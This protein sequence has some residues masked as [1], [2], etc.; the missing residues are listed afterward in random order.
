MHVIATAGHVDHGK[1]TLV[2]RLTSMEPDR[3]SEERR[4]GLTIDLGFAWTTLDDGQR[5]AFVDVPGHERFV[6]NML[7]GIGEVPAVMFVVAADEG[8]MPQSEEHLAALDAL[9]VR[10]GLLAVTRSDLTDPRPATELVLERIGRTSLGRLPA[11]AVSGR[12]GEGVTELRAR[13]AELVRGLPAPDADADVRLW[14]D[15]S[16]S[17]RGAGT[18]V[19][20]TL[21]GGTITTEDELEV[22]S[23]GQAVRVRGIQTLGERT[24]GVSGLAR[25][26][27]N[28]RGVDTDV[29]TRG[30]ALVTPQA[31]RGTGWVDVALREHDGDLPGELV[32]HVGSAAVTVRP[33]RL[34][35]GLARLHLAR[36]LPLRYGDVALLRD[37]GQHIV[38]DGLRVL[39]VDP[40]GLTRRGAARARAAQLAELTDRSKASEQQ[41]RRR[42]FV[43]AGDL[44]WM[45]L[46][47]AGVELRGWHADPQRWRNAQ[48]EL[49]A[50]VRA[51]QSSHPLQPG[52]PV[53]VVRQRLG[54]PHGLANEAAR[55]TG[56]SIVDGQVRFPDAAA[57]LPQRVESALAKLERDLA[58]NPFVAPEAARLAELKLDPKALAAAVR[59]GRLLKIADGIVLLPGAEERAAEILATLDSPFTLSQA[60]KALGTTRRVAVPLLELLDRKGFTER[61]PDSTRRMRQA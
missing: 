46:T 29:I 34:G 14:V 25:I 27:V 45:G 28:L 47:G 50:L 16:F 30:D 12:T 38:V 22:A 36:P 19:T 6:P 59:A 3:W 5:L 20:G 9:G 2:R 39:D 21:R 41:V 37:P 7:A 49:P 8:W 56:L 51:W 54:L 35:P 15:R 18:V 11:V 55:A 1:S 52:V 26:A 48:R 31:W 61:L 24:S 42:G 33:R 53:E 13:L 17:V 10:H 23:T 43:S 60:R 44:R 40:P 4:R 57:E 32:L 58:E